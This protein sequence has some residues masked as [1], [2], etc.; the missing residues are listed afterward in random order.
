[1]EQ[2]Q[3]YENHYKDCAVSSHIYKDWQKKNGVR[4]GKKYTKTA[5][6]T[7]RSSVYV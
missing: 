7:V 5:L 1:M 6:R 3:L 4:D 2:K